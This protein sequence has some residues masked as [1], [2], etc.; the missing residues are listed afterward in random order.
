MYKGGY[1]IRRIPEIVAVS[2]SALVHF[3]SDDAFNMSGFNLTYRL[4]ACPSKISGVD[5]SGNGICI[6]QVCTCDGGWTGI[7]CH[8]QKCPDNCGQHD[9]RGRCE[10]EYGCR[11]ESD[12]KGDDCS[13]FA[14]NGYWETVNV[15]S[16][17]PPGSASHGAAVWRDSM[18]VI[19]GESY[20]RRF[21]L[22]VYDF[23]G[24]I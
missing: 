16:F 8:L 9:G 11:C 13:Q 5:C 14:P 15:E 6:D 10:P 20:S 3:F 12:Y 17:V 4:N 22:Y 18:Y 24:K 19:A 1:S 23:N 7:A 2:G 21:M